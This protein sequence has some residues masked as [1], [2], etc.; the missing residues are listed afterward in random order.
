MAVVSMLVLVLVQDMPFTESG[1]SPDIIIN[2]HAF[3]SR[4]TIG[5]LVE[6]MAA[7]AGALHGHFQDATPFRFN[8]KHRVV[9][10]FG[11]QLRK[12]GYNYYG[13]EP[14]YS[15]TNGTEVGAALRVMLLVLCVDSRVAV[16]WSFPSAVSSMPTSTSVSCTTS[17][18]DTWCL[19]R[20]RCAL[21]APSTT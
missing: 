8:E 14:L 15:G 1:M 18:C 7:K 3:P 16:A 10:Y 5:M 9:D 4:M 12:A 13:S 17:D 19:T 11:E 2:P 20:H 6:S 21:L